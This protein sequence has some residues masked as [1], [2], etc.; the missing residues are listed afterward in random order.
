M[1]FGFCGGIADVLADL[2]RRQT[3]RDLHQQVQE[4]AVR[5][6]LLCGVI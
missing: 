5:L 3:R 2:D 6:T 4:L 1:G